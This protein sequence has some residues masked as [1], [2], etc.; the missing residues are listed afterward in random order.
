M[1]ITIDQ[2]GVPAGT[3]KIHYKVTYLN[4]KAYVNPAQDVNPD[5]GTYK[6]IDIDINENTTFPLTGE[7]E[8]D[9]VPESVEA[10][11]KKMVTYRIAQASIYDIGFDSTPISDAITSDTQ[12]EFLDFNDWNSP[13]GVAI[14]GSHYE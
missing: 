14:K 3:S 13:G 5:P 1:T 11:I 8:V 12:A 4:N 2:A 10:S 6:Y 7:F 9:G